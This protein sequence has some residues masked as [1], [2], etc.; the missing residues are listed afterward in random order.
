MIAIKRIF[1]PTDF[2][3]FSKHALRYACAFAEQFDA[4]LHLVHV[5]Q[6]IIWYAPEMGS[7]TPS[8]GNYQ[9][10]LR[11]SA[12]QSL[13][14]VL[15]PEWAAGR[16]VVRSIREGTPFV[17]IIRYAKEQDIDLI[18]MATHGR[19]GL[20][21]VLLGSVAERVVRKARSPV[22]TVRHPE[23]EFVMP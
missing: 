14:K 17:E 7:V 5:L 2:S 20:S 18:V 11:D 10:E 22:L 9:Q 23:H 8:L 15:D 16:S 21:H 4:E 1:V 3:D 6:D 13:A 12:E 19:T